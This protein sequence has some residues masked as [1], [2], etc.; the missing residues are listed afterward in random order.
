MG[1]WVLLG[2]GTGSSR[3]A[4]LRAA[5]SALLDSGRRTPGT[6]GAALVAC[7][8]VSHSVPP[9]LP[10]SLSPSPPQFA[11]FFLFPECEGLVQRLAAAFPNAAYKQ[12]RPGCPA[13]ASPVP[14]VTVWAG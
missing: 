3:L 12:A 7:A 1:G 13:L 6:T 2:A 14:C 4:E 8:G 9:S 11:L 10:P 5:G